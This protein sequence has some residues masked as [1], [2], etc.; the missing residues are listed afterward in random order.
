MFIRHKDLLTN[1]CYHSYFIFVANMIPESL[2]ITSM[3]LLTVPN[4]ITYY[5]TAI[6]TITAVWQAVAHTGVKTSDINVRK[7][8]AIH[9]RCSRSTWENVRWSSPRRWRDWNIRRRNTPTH[10]HTYVQLGQIASTPTTYA[11][12]KQSDPITTNQHARV[13]QSQKRN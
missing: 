3:L 11:Q 2:L 12:V 4:L 7:K 1:L 8:N 6:Y 9:T 13:H 10:T 5:I